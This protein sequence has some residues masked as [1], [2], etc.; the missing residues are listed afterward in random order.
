M[1]FGCDRDFSEQASVSGEAGQAAATVALNVFDD[2]Q[3]LL[4][5]HL[6]SH[7]TNVQNGRHMLL[8]AQSE[9]VSL[10][11]ASRLDVVC[12]ADVMIKVKITKTFILILV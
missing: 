2:V 5:L 6:T 10:A 12:S 7:A 4:T 3:D 8:P 9:D 11:L 1:D